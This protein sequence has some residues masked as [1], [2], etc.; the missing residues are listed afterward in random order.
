MLVCYSDRVLQCYYFMNILLCYSVSV[1]VVFSSYS[2]CVVIY[3]NC[4]I[5]VYSTT[6]DQEAVAREG[7][8]PSAEL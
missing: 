7:F 1:R 4:L 8:H 6:A 3:L 2:L 5:A